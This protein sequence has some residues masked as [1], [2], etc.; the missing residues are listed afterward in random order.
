MHINWVVVFEVNI[1]SQVF[2]VDDR[3]FLWFLFLLFLRFLFLLFG[4]WLKL[5]SFSLKSWF[6]G[7]FFFCFHC[8]ARSSIKQFR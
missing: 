2:V 6:G 8:F 3:F 4:S 5:G 1:D 7:R